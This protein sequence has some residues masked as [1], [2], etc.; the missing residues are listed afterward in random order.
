MLRVYVHYFEVL[1]N[2]PI[3]RSRVEDRY[4]HIDRSV[5]KQFT[6]RKLNA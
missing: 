4:V 3:M 6:F 2:F 1:L 5:R